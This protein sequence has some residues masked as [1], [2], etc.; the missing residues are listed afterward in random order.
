MRRVLI[1]FVFLIHGLLV[2]AD[3]VNWENHPARPLAMSPDGSTLASGG[4]DGAVRLWDAVWDWTRAC[5][6]ADPYVAASQLESYLP[7]G[8]SPS[9]CQLG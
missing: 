7:E 3:Y 1:G 4:E 5:E 8:Q 2:H 9:G 6:L